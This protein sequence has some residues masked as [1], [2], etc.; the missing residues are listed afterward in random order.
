MIRKF[1][2]SLVAALTIISACRVL[3]A[4]ADYSSM[5]TYP[6]QQMYEYTDFSKLLKS[7]D[8]L[9]H[10]DEGSA[11]V[12][13]N[14]RAN[15]SVGALSKRLA[16]TRVGTEGSGEV[17]SLY[18]YYKANGSKYRVATQGTTLDIISDTAG[19]ATNIDTGLTSGKR[20][21]FVTYKDNVIGMNG[22]DNAQKWDG[23][24]QTTTNTTGS[25]SAGLLTAD[26]GAPF[27]TQLTGAN[28]TASRWYQYRIAYS[29]GIN[30]WYST[31]RSNPILTGSTVKDITLSDIPL[32][33]VGVTK[34]YIY[35]T[36]AQTSQANVIADNTFYLV[37]TINDNSTRTYA[38]HMA[39][40]TI[41]PDNAPTW[42]TVSGGTAVTVPRGKYCTIHQEFLFIA[43]DPN[44]QS[45]LYYS[46]TLNPDWFDL[47]G[48]EQVRPDDGDAITFIVD[49][50]GVLTIG[51]TNTISKLYTTDVSPANWILTAPF[52]FVGCPAPY[53]VVV[54]PLGIV[55]VGRDGIYQFTGQTSQ[56]ISDVITDKVRDF[57]QTNV[58]DFAG[59]FFRNEYHLA[60]TST[61][62]GSA[63]NDEVIVLDMVRNAYEIDTQK[64]SSWAVLNSGTDFGVLES[65]SSFDGAIYAHNATPTVLVEKTK[66][67][68]NT[69]TTSYVDI[70]G[71]E[72]NP[73]MS[74]GWGSTW[75][76]VGI[77]TWS[78]F[79]A[80]STWAI[81]SQSG[82]WTSTAIQISATALQKLYWNPTLGANGNITFAVK[83]A[84]SSGGLPGASWST[85]F[86]NSA[87]ADLSGLTAN[88]WIQIRATFTTTDWVTSPS[89][90]LADNFVIKLAYQQSGS[91][92]ESSFLTLYA[93]GFNNF[94]HASLP[95]RIRSVDV[96]YTGI[97]GTLNVGLSNSEGTFNINIPIDLSHA[98]DSG[99]KP[100]YR[101]TAQGVKIYH[102]EPRINS[103]TTPSP[104]GEN[105]QLI[106]NE[107]GA[108]PWTIAR[109]SVVYDVL[110]KQTQ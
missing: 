12:A 18:R 77:G 29:D 74:L 67:D 25:R 45:Y 59:S 94:G 60:C 85:E 8:S 42:A 51:K 72:D 3:P 98:P 34:R 68:L 40:A 69:G 22:Y 90:F 92:S 39:D 2:L 37:D 102:F 23:T 103:I 78:N 27:A 62:T 26:L 75:A 76:T 109:I 35:R 101:G 15:L 46:N 79:G 83:S 7:N 52:S 5:Q 99:M 80:N 53:S 44:N 32:G 106:V 28:L 20:W 105:W 73:T 63:Y 49:Y 57:N 87:G 19:T 10:S 97:Q 14:L 95:K 56:L 9:Y 24:T 88:T 38:D 96:Y 13:Q 108:S 30:Y 4:I 91:N 82:T 100:I 84:S 66:S 11:N 36:L 31:N 48:Y 61:A 110:D 54:T 41:S 55:Y 6:Q 70:L 104:I 86:S 21:Q 81:Q 50:L 71:T 89:L 64:I 93:S 47:T 107:N 58:N 1:Y 43:G 33:A 17:T 65:G 16:M